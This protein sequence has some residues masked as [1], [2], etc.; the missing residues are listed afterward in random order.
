MNSHPAP[1][2]HGHGHGQ[3][4]LDTG[5]DREE[6][7]GHLVAAHHWPAVTRF[8]ATAADLDD[9]HRAYHDPARID[10]AVTR[11]RELLAMPSG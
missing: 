4:E 11:T 3:D 10:E 2:G 7:R 5:H 8:D 1:S 6:T 9:L